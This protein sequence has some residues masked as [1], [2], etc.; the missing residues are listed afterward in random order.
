MSDKWSDTAP[1]V[2][3]RILPRFI[4]VEDREKS[5]SDARAERMSIRCVVL[6]PFLVFEAASLLAVECRSGRSVLHDE[7]EEYLSWAQEGIGAV[8][9]GLF[10][11][12]TVVGR[13]VEE[14]VA[15]QGDLIARPAI[16]ECCREEGACR[17]VRPILAQEGIVALQLGCK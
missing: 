9:V 10:G 5:L 7:I 17:V 13:L 6:W 3:I 11:A 2:F 12:V 1:S 16:G 4:G 14:I 15:R 8:T